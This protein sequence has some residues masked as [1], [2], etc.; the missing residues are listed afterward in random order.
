MISDFLDLFNL[1]KREEKALITNWI[2]KRHVELQVHT[3]ALST[4]TDT[5]ER[6]QSKNMSARTQYI[7]NRYESLNWDK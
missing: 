3:P 4:M 1:N 5:T 6:S 2:K 7:F